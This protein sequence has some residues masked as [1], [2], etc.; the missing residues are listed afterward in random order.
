MVRFSG[1]PQI[2]PQ[3]RAWGHHF[4]VE[5]SDIRKQVSLA[6]VTTLHNAYR[7]NLTV[8]F[9]TN[10]AGVSTRTCNM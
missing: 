3:N 10:L 9:L 4:P 5:K 6:W 8:I 7:G 1:Y 2:N